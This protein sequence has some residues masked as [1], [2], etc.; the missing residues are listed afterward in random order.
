VAESSSNARNSSAA[1]HGCDWRSNTNTN[2]NTNTNSHRHAEAHFFT[3]ASSDTKA[4]TDS[5]AK[6]L[7]RYIRNRQG[8]TKVSS[9]PLTSFAI[10]RFLLRC[11]R[12]RLTLGVRDEAVA[13]GKPGDAGGED[14]GEEHYGCCEAESDTL[15]E[16]AVGNR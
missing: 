2:T 13:A 14:E 10:D 4:E 6:T 15:D 9:E 8:A 16:V 3:K 7:I 12:S 11:E 5:A 1:L